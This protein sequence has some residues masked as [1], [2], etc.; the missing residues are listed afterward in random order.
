MSNVP[1][2]AQ[3]RYAIA[4]WVIAAG[5]LFLTLQVKL[6]PALLAGLLVYELV[7]VIASRLPWTREGGGKLAAVTLLAIAIVGLLTL[8]LFGIVAFRRSDAGSLPRLLQKMAEIVESSRGKL[9]AWLV[10]TIPGDPDALK[11]VT[12]EWLREHARELRTLGGEIGHVIAHLLIGMVIG[13]VVSLHEARPTQ[14]G[15]PL[16]R[17]LAERARRGGDALRRV[18]FAHIRISALNSIFA[19]FYLSGLLP[20]LGFHLPSSPTLLALPV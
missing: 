2:D 4:A 14:D 20:R 15:G 6:L 10:D 3:L 12:I 13:A 9:P 7:H 18:G 19:S 16:A 17:A 8:V 11:G 5:L 1:K